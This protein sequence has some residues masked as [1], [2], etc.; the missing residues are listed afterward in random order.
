MVALM[1]KLPPFVAPG[2][3][4]LL[5][6]CQTPLFS[7]GLFSSLSPNKTLTTQQAASGSGRSVSATKPRIGGRGWRNTSTRAAVKQAQVPATGI[8][9][10]G[11]LREFLAKGNDAMQKGM[12]DD[13]RIQYETVL[14]IEPHHATAHHMLGRISDMSKKFNDAERHYLAALSSNREDGYLLSDLGYSYLQQGKL[15]E[16]RQYL[17][18]AITREPDLVIAK[19]NLAAVYAYAGDQKGALAWLRQVGN[20]QQARDNLAEILSKPAPYVFNGA[21]GALAS[22]DKYTISKDGQVLDE[23]GIA[24]T[25]FDKIKEA[26]GELK[27]AARRKQA[28]ENEVRTY[29]DDRRIQGALDQRAFAGAGAG[30]RATDGS[31]LNR[32]MQAIDQASGTER[33]RPRNSGPI[34]IGP[35]AQ[36]NG[37]TQGNA[38]GQ[39]QSQNYGNAPPR[40]D[41][42]PHGQIQQHQP[43]SQQ[44]QFAPP[45]DPYSHLLNPAGPTGFAQQGYPN[46]QVPQGQP[47]GQGSSVPPQFLG[48]PPAQTQ[49]PN[50]LLRMDLMLRNDQYQNPNLVPGQQDGRQQFQPQQAIQ[51]IPNTTLP[52]D[53][54]GHPI[55]S[56]PQGNPAWSGQPGNIQPTQGST[57]PNPGFYGQS[58]LQRDIGAQPR[59]YSTNSPPLSAQSPTGQ[60]GQPGQY[61]NGNGY[62][63]GQPAPLNQ[64]QVDPRQRNQVQSANGWNN[65]QQ[66]P[67]QQLGFDE[68]R[69]MAR[70]DRGQRILQYSDADRQAMQL[71]MAAGFGSLSPIDTTQGQTPQSNQQPGNGSFQGD[72]RPYNSPQNNVVPNGG[73]QQPSAVAPANS[74]FSYGQ[75]GQ[76]PQQTQQQPYRGYPGAVPANSGRPPGHAN[77]Q[78]PTRQIQG[79]SI[80]DQLG[81]DP[82]TAQPW[83]RMPTSQAD[84]TTPVAFSSSTQPTEQQST[85]WQRPDLANQA[86]ND[87]VLA[88]PTTQPGFS[89]PHMTNP[90]LRQPGTSSNQQAG[91]QE[92]QTVA[93]GSQHPRSGPVRN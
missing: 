29:K 17:T 36:N 49:P 40:P 47:G 56:N 73:L 80:A 61:Q 42:N 46:Q 13:A 77:I 25:T 8:N 60:I 51:R 81:Q 53:Q 19:V 66:Q 74:G 64:G 59:V 14:S 75:P 28:Y 72:G 84:V 43:G 21:A 93:W 65:P 63:S 70:I 37:S 11:Q 55:Q 52:R 78:A 22:N 33:Q 86:W 23:N 68:Q 87:G 30:N 4:L 10:I 38:Q 18:Q 58:N 24:L 15:G 82:Q 62:P 35:P 34:S 92:V 6:G 76:Y 79:Q 69:P 44:G 48:P 50:E 31:N 20:E 16:A 57:A 27:A 91:N 45:Q 71:G 9:N 1:R 2:L 90:H 89:Q 5:A 88:S 83:L 67:I 3:C 32:Q 85:N 41:Q 26:M 39:Y 54:Y 7:D 12:F